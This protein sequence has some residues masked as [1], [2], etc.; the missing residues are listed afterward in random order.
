MQENYTRQ[1]QEAIKLAE[2]TA[3]KYKHNYVGTEHLLMGLLK[4]SEGT[5]GA[6]LAEFRIDEEKL[7]TLIEKLIAPPAEV[8]TDG[9]RGYTPRAQKVIEARKRPTWKRTKSAPSI[10]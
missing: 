9:P 4:Q 5:A 6:T 8:L 7:A 1:A 3:R 10:C 2:E